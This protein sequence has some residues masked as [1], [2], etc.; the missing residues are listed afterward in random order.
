MNNFKINLDDESGRNYIL[1]KARQS[2]KSMMT[3]MSFLNDWNNLIV[4]H[5]R[6]EKIKNIFNI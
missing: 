2:G 4:K 5:N 3:A 6:R 1:M